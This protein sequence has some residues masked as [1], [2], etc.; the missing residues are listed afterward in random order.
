MISVLFG[1][2]KFLWLPPTIFH[3]I[4][5]TPHATPP[6]LSNSRMRKWR[7][8]DFGGDE[9]L[10]VHFILFKTQDI[11]P[12]EGGR[13]SYKA[14]INFEFVYA[15]RVLISAPKTLRQTKTDTLFK[16]DWN[17]NLEILKWND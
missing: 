9:S 16:G 17:K 5:G 12:L 15:V 7:G 8:L 6:L 14:P 11:S 3:K 10:P 13:C 1:L 2:S 4:D